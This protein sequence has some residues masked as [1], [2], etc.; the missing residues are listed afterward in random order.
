M[1]VENWGSSYGTSDCLPLFHLEF[2]LGQ[3]FLRTPLHHPS[4]SKRSHCLFVGVF[5]STLVGKVAITT[6]ACMWRGACS[7]NRYQSQPSTD[8]FIGAKKKS[9]S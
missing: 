4:S 5:V 2:S 1:W 8:S 3:E 9:D 7:F 6:E